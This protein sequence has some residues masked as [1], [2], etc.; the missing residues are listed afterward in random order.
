MFLT[1]VL[2]PTGGALLNDAG[3]DYNAPAKAR[4]TR[5]TPENHP[6]SQGK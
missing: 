1:F 6:E 5:N 3:L 2:G 4:T